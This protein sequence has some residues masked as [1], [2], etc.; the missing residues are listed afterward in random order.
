MPTA[1]C[2]R[3]WRACRPK[4]QSAEACSAPKMP[5]TPHSSLSLS[6]SKGWVLIVLAISLLRALDQLVEVFAFILV[7]SR[8]GLGRRGFRR[9]LAHGVECLLAKLLLDRVLRRISRLAAFAERVLRQEGADQVG[10]RRDHAQALGLL[11]HVG[12]VFRLGYRPGEEEIGEADQHRTPRQAEKESKRP[13]ECAEAAAPD[14]AGKHVAD[15]GADEQGHY[16]NADAG[17]DVGQKIALDV[18]ARERAQMGKRIDRDDRG[19]HPGADGQHLAHEAPAEGHQAGNDENP[20]DGDV[21]RIERQMVQAVRPPPVRS[22]PIRSTPVRPPPVRSPPKRSISALTWSTGWRFSPLPATLRRPA[23]LGIKASVKPNFSASLRRCS[24]WP[25]ALTSP[26]SPIS[27][28][29]TSPAGTGRS[30]R[31]E[32]S[33]A[34]TAR[35]AAGSPI[36]S[37]PATFKYTSWPERVSSTASSMASRPPSQPTTA[38]RGV[39]GSEGASSA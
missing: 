36:L 33:A 26:P 31:E 7:I 22:A 13:V 34:A 32:T 23:D 28:K 16:E 11:D 5:T 30:N 2:P 14:V 4:A 8:I 24:V 6:S 25:T 12:L 29:I 18:D 27:P 38:R 37:P 19:T 35:S 39:P 9:R 3:C 10:P 21:D 15:G 20:D 17:G 1:S